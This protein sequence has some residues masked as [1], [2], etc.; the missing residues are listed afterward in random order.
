MQQKKVSLSDIAKILGVSKSTVSFV[1][2]NKGDKYN[3]SKE[4]QKLILDKAKEL[5]FVPNFFA[6]NLRQGKTKTIGL[7]VSD[8][9]NP[10]YGELSKII[11]EELNKHDYKLFIVNTNDSKDLELHVFRDLLGRSIDAMI[12]SPCNV[13]DDLKEILDSTPIPVVFVDRFGDNFADFVGINNKR[14]AEQLLSYFSTKPKK[15]GIFYQ[16]VHEVSTVRLRIDGIIEACNKGGVEYELVNISDCKD[17]Q[18]RVKKIKKMDAVISLNNRAALPVIAA[19]NGI[20]LSI[21]EDVR[22]ICFDDA[23]AFQYISPPISALRQPIFEIGKET[24]NQMMRRLTEEHI[25]GK[26]VEFTCEFMERGS[27]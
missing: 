14:E 9:S 23:Q 11:Q 12:I 22:F 20:G 5:N 8:I 26:W 19:L 27:H 3:I 7:V 6:K 18:A 13:I 1:L 24:V 10:F 17:L 2:N 4:T 21:P 15:V 25:P 16:E